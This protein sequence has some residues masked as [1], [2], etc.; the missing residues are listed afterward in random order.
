MNAMARP[1]EAKGLLDSLYVALKPGSH[2]YAAVGLAILMACAHIPM[3]ALPLMRHTLWAV[4][5]VADLIVSASL[6]PV[7]HMNR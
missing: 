5:K 4:P 3:L 7:Q 6:A 2:R 1:D